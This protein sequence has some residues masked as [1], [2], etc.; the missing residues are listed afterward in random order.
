[1]QRIRLRRV[2]RKN[3]PHYQV[4]VTPHTNSAKGSF[5]AKLGWYNPTT[6]E[7][8]IDEKAILSWL[9]SGAQPSNTMAK[10]LIKAG[11]KHKLIVYK[12]DAP[13][14]AKKVE[15]QEKDKKPAQ[16]ENASEKETV[17]DE[18]EEHV[19][20]PAQKVS[21][22]NNQSENNQEEAK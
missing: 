13:K 15:K 7:L 11:V 9:N 5:T 16:I 22:A 1:M 2:G 10:L 12:Q 20:E 17:A 19:E 14:K 6:K 4:V 8:K 18:T 3:E 21:N